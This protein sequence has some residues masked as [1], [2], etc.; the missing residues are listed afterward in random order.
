V[1]FLNYDPHDPNDKPDSSPRAWV[2]GFAWLIAAIIF[3]IG[4][5]AIAMF[6][7]DHLH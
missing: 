6:L 7:I 3:L 4:L 1:S 5:V 2:V